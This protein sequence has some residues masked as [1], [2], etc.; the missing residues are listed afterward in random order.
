MPC[1][2]TIPLSVTVWLAIC[3]ANF[4]GG[5]DR[6]IFLHKGDRAPMLQEAQ[7]FL[8]VFGPVAMYYRCSLKTVY[9]GAVENSHTIYLFTDQ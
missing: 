5:S 9:V 3:I 6:Q 4:A 1:I 7:L 8:P 2:V